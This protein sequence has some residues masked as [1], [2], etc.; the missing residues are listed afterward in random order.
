MLRRILFLAV[1]ALT[2]VMAPAPIGAQPAPDA[3]LLRLDDLPAGWSDTDSDAPAGSGEV[4][5]ECGGGAPVVPV[6][7]ALAQFAAGPEG[8]FL[9]QS[10]A[11]FAPGDADRAWAY[12]SY[13]WSGCGGTRT[14]DPP[15]RPVSIADLGDA[16]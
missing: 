11:V 12:L 14:D 8:P 9:L 5:D 6:S 7:H 2:A 13:D 4:G 10:V 16:S 1:M 3:A 15:F